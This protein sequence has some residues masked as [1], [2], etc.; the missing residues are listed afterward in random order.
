MLEERVHVVAQFFVSL[1]HCFFDLL[2]GVV[3]EFERGASSILLRDFV[4]AV[5]AAVRGGED[6]LDERGVR[7]E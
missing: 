5:V 1:S 4:C 2:A 6:E 7:G 3:L